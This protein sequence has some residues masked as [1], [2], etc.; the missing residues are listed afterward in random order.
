MSLADGKSE[1]CF[2]LAGQIFLVIMAK[3]LDK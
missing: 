3:V 1:T 2:R